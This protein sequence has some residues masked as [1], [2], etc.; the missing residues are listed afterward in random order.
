MSQT[1]SVPLWTGSQEF[2]GLLK[3]LLV[4]A[5]RGGVAFDHSW[6]FR[7]EDDHPN[8]MVEVTLLVSDPNTTSTCG[9]FAPKM[10]EVEFE[11]ELSSLHHTAHR[12]GVGFDRAWTFRCADG[13]DVM[14]E[15]TWLAE[16]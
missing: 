6:A 12:S 8:L 13:L 1:D 2:E 14:V 11:T 3:A 7:S 10:G 16:R 9:E 5:H 15:I 4:A